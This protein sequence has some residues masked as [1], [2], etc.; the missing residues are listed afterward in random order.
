MLVIFLNSLMNK[1]ANVDTEVAMNHEKDIINKQCHKNLLSVL[2]GEVE[3]E[4][5]EEMITPDK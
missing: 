2:D 1:A 3:E 5:E 4:K